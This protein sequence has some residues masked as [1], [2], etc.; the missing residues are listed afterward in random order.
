MDSDNWVVQNLQNALD[1][2]NGKLAEIW[3]I[4]T[5]SP[6]TFKGGGIWKAIVD[7]HGALQA[8]AYALL[9]LF[10]VIGVV[11][12]CG[13]FTEVKKPEH[14]LKLF[15]RF[16]IAKGVITYGLELMMALFQIV[17]GVIS[18]IMKTA[19]FGTAKKTVLP[20]E[21]VTA[22]ED[23]GFFESIPLWAV[24]LIGGLFITVLSFIMI[25]S[26]YGRFFRLY[27]YT[28][29]APLPLSAFAGE[30]SQN[31]GKSF[32]K[33]YA[34]VCLEGAIIV[35]ACIIFSLF[36]T[37]PPVVNPEAAA[38]TMVWSYIGEL[39]FNMLVL[40]GAVKMADRVVREMM[41]L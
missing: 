32:L 2:W 20:N 15:V 16:A 10:F 21:I 24:T 3:Q 37:S 26:V 36:A 1:T 7:I 41:G 35:L 6:E 34:A 39:V 27:L 12:T 4:L 13:S 40:V 23:C 28:A 25:M 8:V 9:V 14:A 33:S 38:V 19:G 17:Q 31:V 30:P 22:V 18:T 5:Q 29:I 11:K